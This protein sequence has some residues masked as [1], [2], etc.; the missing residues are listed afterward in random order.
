VTEE[1]PLR[2]LPLTDGL[3][4]TTGKNII[5]RGREGECPKGHIPEKCYTASYK[6][7]FRSSFILYGD[8]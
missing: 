3:L 1:A 8:I 2:S 5:T 7:R 4:I 6:G